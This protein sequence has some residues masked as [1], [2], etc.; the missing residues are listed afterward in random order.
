MIA[1]AARRRLRE[2]PVVQKV[3]EVITFVLETGVTNLWRVTKR[4]WTPNNVIS[5]C[6]KRHDDKSFPKSFH[7]TIFQWAGSETHV[8]S[9]PVPLGYL[10][11]GL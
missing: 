8:S 11:L 1:D 7:S 6:N 2:F 3:G 9:P 10:R 5:L 4:H